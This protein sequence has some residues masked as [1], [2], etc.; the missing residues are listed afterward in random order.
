MKMSRVHLLFIIL[1]MVSSQIW[2]QTQTIRG[3]VLD[4]QSKFPLIGANVLIVGSNPLIGAATDV[5]GYFVINNVPLGRHQVRI[6]YLG[7][8]EQTIPNVIV[9]AGKQTELNVALEESIEMGEEIVIKAKKDKTLTNNEMA[10]LSARGFTI[11]ETS[12]YAGSRNDP[13]RMAQNFAGVSGANDSRNDIIIRGNSPVG[14]LWRLDGID[15]PNPSHFGSLGTTGGPVSMLNYNT[16]ANSDFLTGAF[17]ADYGNSVSGAFDLQMR[18]G[19]KSKKEYTGQIGFNGF[20]LGAEGP[21]AKGSNATYLVNYR[22]TATPVYDALGISLGTGGALP[23][24]QDLSFKIDVP[25][26]KAG[27]FSMFGVGGIS[28]I[29]LLDSET[30][31]DPENLFSQNSED[32]RQ[33]TNMGVV[34][35]NHLYFFNKNTFSQLSLA[36]S[37]ASENVTLDSVIRNLTTKAVEQLIFSGARDFTQVKY[38]VREQINHKFN[39]RNTINL[40]VIFDWYQVKMIDS[41]LVDNGT[42]FRR[43]NDFTGGSALL[44]GYIQWQHR[45]NE[46]LTLNAGMHYQQFLFNNTNSLEP[47]LALK[48]KITPTQSIGV[49]AGMHSQLQPLQIYF[50]EQNGTL[51]NENLGL[52][53]SNHLVL[54]YDNSLA[55]DL[56]LK[57]EAYYQQLSNIPVDPNLPQFSMANAGTDFGI[58]LRDGLVSEGTGINYGVEI[59]LEK[60]YSK[61]YYFLVTGSFFES[62][63]EG[64]DRVERN[65]AFNGNFVANGLFGKEWKVGK[66]N[67]FTVD[68][69]TTYAGGRRVV[70]IDLAASQTQNREVLIYEQAYEQKLKD[71]FRLDFRIGFRLN[72]KRITQEWFIDIQNMTNHRNIAT[73]AYSPVTQS[74]LTTYQLGWFPLMQWRILF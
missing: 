59:T 69:K 16:L 50:Q 33:K 15:I 48:Y 25:T 61:G 39:A 23:I 43:F 10:L 49:G 42:R 68:I 56:R 27:R 21:F 63:Y 45:F 12:R 4:K 32:V 54:T 18:T 9:N 55:A 7:Y 37:R 11:E 52:T 29:D 6:T 62:K 19:N 3:R 17:P 24:Y 22:Y 67:A 66:G 73:N 26:K 31:F 60:F 53:K 30:D 58:P 8:T 41:A 65:T 71:Y 40:G 36:V 44:R 51:T 35:L 74:I 13:S 47:R 1:F 64:F 34:G 2:A 72:E 57:V 38:T 20:E 28:N 5:D 14:L 46:R 70:P